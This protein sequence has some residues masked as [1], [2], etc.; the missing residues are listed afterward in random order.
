MA[1]SEGDKVEWDWGSGAGQG[2]VKKIY[3]QKTTVKIKGSEITRDA[4]DDCP[5]YPIEQQDGDEV[6]KSDSEVRRA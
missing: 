5:A 2:A 4:D 3:T 1:I 6:L